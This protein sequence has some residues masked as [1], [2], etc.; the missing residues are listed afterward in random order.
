MI[1]VGP[2]GALYLR[3]VATGFE[4]DRDAAVGLKMHR[5]R[6]GG[7]MPDVVIAVRKRD[8]ARFTHAPEQ[9]RSGATL[10]VRSYITC[11]GSIA[12]CKARAVALE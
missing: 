12:H 10:A 5:Q 7:V 6:G 1:Y 8:E 4:M 9:S 2:E 3:L 11:R